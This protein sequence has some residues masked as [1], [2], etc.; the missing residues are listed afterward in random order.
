MRSCAGPG[1]RG[2]DF[3][4]RSF[5]A[6]CRVV[7]A[8]QGVHCVLGTFMAEDSDVHS[9]VSSSALSFVCHKSRDQ[10]ASVKGIKILEVEGSPSSS[11]A[12]FPS[13]MLF[14]VVVAS[15]DRD[16]FLSPWELLLEKRQLCLQPVSQP[17][18]QARP[19]KW[20]ET[21]TLQMD[22]ATLSCA[23]DLNSASISRN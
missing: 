16:R 5:C 15:S 13:F 23:C 21:K 12:A 10:S 6:L 7:W 17:C 18:A 3:L 8:G 19:S 11:S 1:R 4:A 20:R 9:A 2:P 14:L 22:A